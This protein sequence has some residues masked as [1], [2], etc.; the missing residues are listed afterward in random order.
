MTFRLNSFTPIEKISTLYV[1]VQL[2]MQGVWTRTKVN[3]KLLGAGVDLQAK[4]NLI[5]KVTNKI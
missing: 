2:N 4:S 3:V 5:P 1:C